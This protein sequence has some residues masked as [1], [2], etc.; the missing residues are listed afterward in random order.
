MKKTNLDQK[1]LL[2]PLRCC[3]AFILICLWVSTVYAQ[4]H[5]D[6]HTKTITLGFVKESLNNALLT[7]EQASGLRL[8]FPNEPVDDTRPIDMPTEERTVEATLRL[9]LQGTNL[10]FQQSGNTIVLFVKKEV[11]R[12][13][14]SP[15]SLSQT[16][17]GIVLDEEGQ[18]LPGAM[19]LVKGNPKKN[20]TTNVGGRFELSDVDPTTVLVVSFMGYETVEIL[21][22]TQKELSVHMKESATALKDVV[23]TGMFSR[24]AESFTGSF[25][26]YTRMDFQNT[27]VVNLFQSIK[28]LDPSLSIMENLTSGSDPNAILDMQ[29]RGASS[30]PDIQNRYSSNPN[31]PLFIVDG[32]EARIEH[33]MDMDMN[34]V[35]SV[36]ILKDATAKAIYGSKAANGVIV[37]ETIKLQPG[38]IRLEYIGG[39]SISIPDLSSYNMCNASEKLELERILGLYNS[40][41][42]AIDIA[43]KALYYHNLEEVRRGVNT[44]WLAQPLRTAVSNKHSV[45]LE[46][47]DDKL[48]IGLDLGYNDIQGVMKDS[49]RTILN[50]NVNVVYRFK[51]LSFNNMLQLN[52]TNTFDSPYGDF[53]D[54]ARLNPYWRVRDENGRLLSFLGYGPVFSSS[55]FNPMTDAA[56]GT[57]Y[58]GNYFN[59]TNNSYLEWTINS[60]F[61]LR[62]RFSFSKENSTSER[63]RP[64]SHSSFQEILPGDDRFFL[65]GSYDAGYGKQS[66]MGGDINLSFNQAWGKHG[67]Y[68]NLI[69]NIRQNQG[70]TTLYKAEGFPNQKMDNIM[71]AKQYALDSKPAGSEMLDREVGIVLSANY[72][73]DER[74]L[75]DLS[76]RESASSQFGANNRWGTFWATGIGWNVHNEAFFKNSNVVTL[77]K[78]RGSMGYTGSQSFNSA[79]AMLSYNYYLDRSYQGLIGAY[80]EAL[81]NS[82][83]K[84]QQ[85]YDFNVGLNMNLF[86]RLDIKFDLYKTITTDLLT[87][88]NIPPSLGFST[89]VANLGEI[90]NNGYEFG[91]NYKIFARGY[92][93]TYLSVFV[94]GLHNKNKITKISNSLQ[95]INKAQDEESKTDNRPLVRFE[96]GQ[97]LTA[98]WAVKSNGID[99]ATGKE[100]FVKKDGTLTDVWDVEDKVVCGDTEPILRGNFGLNAEYKG[101]TFN[102]TFQYRIGGQIY[103]QTLINKVENAAMNY[104]VDRRAY[105][106]TWQNPGDMV[107]FKNVGDWRNPTLATSRFVQDINTLDIASI[108]IGYDFYRFAFVRKMKLQRLQM[109]VNMNDVANFSTVRIERGTAYPFARMISYTLI[110]NF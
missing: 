1:H 23:V 18:A 83:L 82:D 5:N 57:R 10:D 108:S 110:A 64:S 45:K 28:N 27:G 74:Y 69:T 31:L 102:M 105:Y 6:I 61:T 35:Q 13:V 70:E 9:L 88:I 87:D 100:I 8:V 73:Y 91:L 107:L 80:L 22:S 39:L 42:P 95:A 56:I 24:K 65:K 19:V 67:V 77:L 12:T 32:F 33:V 103:N 104:N 52:N 78:L 60:N 62:G 93:R 37:I 7:L 49:K 79:Q 72:A 36:T 81:A 29:I 109:R 3:G 99:P 59:V 96:E 30:F 44:D 85:K 47:G 11:P 84:W 63:F 90:E 58:A 21:V 17:Q 4:P 14:A 106:D 43:R 92:D 15:P 41:I 98:I 50:G 75:L 89:Y 16:V 53:S 86:D 94:N 40:D 76:L 26:T 34:R 55:V 97:S 46:A 51:N 48:R 20:A 38:E 68:A 2:K 66:V 101:F 25:A 71:F 54:Y